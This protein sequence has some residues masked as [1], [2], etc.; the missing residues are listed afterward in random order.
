MRLFRL[1]RNKCEAA[2]RALR[3]RGSRSSSRQSLSRQSLSRQSLS[4]QSLSRS[5]SQLRQQGKDEGTDFIALNKDLRSIPRRN[6]QQKLYYVYTRFGDRKPMLDEQYLYSGG[7]P[8]SQLKKG[9]R[10]LKGRHISWTTQ[11]KTNAYGNSRQ[12]GL[13]IQF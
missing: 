12:V 4:R 13:H 1:Q 11:N 2:K 10:G 7:R 5:S 9:L 3:S 6:L 8:R